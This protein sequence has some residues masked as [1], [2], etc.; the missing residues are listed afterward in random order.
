MKHKNQQHSHAKQRNQPVLFAA[1]IKRTVFMFPD[2]SESSSIQAREHIVALFVAV[3]LEFNFLTCRRNMVLC[4]VDNS[5]FDEVFFKGGPTTKYFSVCS[6][7]A[8]LIG[9]DSGKSWFL[10][11]LY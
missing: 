11:S 5:S 2:I 7:S 3:K 10:S 6:T 9:Y 1:R 4:R 8:K